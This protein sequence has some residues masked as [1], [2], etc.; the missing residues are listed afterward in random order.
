MTWLQRI[1]KKKGI[2]PNDIVQ[3]EGGRQSGQEFVPETRD[4]STEEL[5]QKL[6]SGI[7]GSVEEENGG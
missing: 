6:Q 7:Y 1:F 3:Q 5:N 4:E 2:S